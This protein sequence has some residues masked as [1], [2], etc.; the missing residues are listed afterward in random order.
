MPS[1][2]EHQD[3][4]AFDQ[5]LAIMAGLE[6]LALSQD[7]QESAEFAALVTKLENALRVHARDDAL[8]KEMGNLAV[9][10]T[11]TLADVR[12]LAAPATAERLST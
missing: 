10:C 2:S 7:G 11:E 8:A 12:A 5:C 6:E 3:P 4:L 1:E 9:A